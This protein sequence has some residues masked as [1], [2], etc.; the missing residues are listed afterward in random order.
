MEINHLLIKRFSLLSIVQVVN[1]VFPIALYLLLI[2]RLSISTVGVIMSWQMVFSILASIS[3]YNF[4]TILIPIAEKLKSQRILFVYWNRLLQIRFF[5]AGIVAFITIICIGFL[6][7]VAALSL[8]IL[9]GKLFNPS[10]YFI[11]LSKNR[12]LLI[13]NFCIR[14]LSFIIVFLFVTKATY[15]WTNFI[16]GCSELLISV[17]VLKQIK[18]SI[19]FKF[20]KVSK[21]FKFLKR[22]RLPFYIQSVN[23]LI[24]MITIP[25]SHLFFG[26]YIAGVISV[27]EKMLML[28][29]GISGNLFFSVLPET[30]HKNDSRTIVLKSIPVFQ[31]ITFAIIL[32]SVAFIFLFK[33]II[34]EK[35][36]AEMPYYLLLAIVSFIPIILSTPFQLLCFKFKRFKTIFYISKVHLFTLVIGVVVFGKL[37]GVYGIISSIIIHETSCYYLY[38]RLN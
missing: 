2:D 13:Y 36:S 18:W 15:Q 20:I 27:V 32:G 23:A 24:I 35:F 14:L 9:I 11:V 6:S 10:A 26:A 19:G 16:I 30:W 28:V 7:E 38:R 29:R 12:L 31:K 37:F 22:E 17:I 5:V 4:P 8:M 33:A 21:L 25:L 3:N 1:S 34:I